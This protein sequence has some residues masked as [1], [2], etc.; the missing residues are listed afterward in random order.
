MRSAQ[1]IGRKNSVIVKTICV[2]SCSIGESH[3]HLSGVCSKWPHSDAGAPAGATPDGH[4]A[5]AAEQGCGGE[6]LS[7]HLAGFGG[8][9]LIGLIAEMR[10]RRGNSS[11]LRRSCVAKLGAD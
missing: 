9:A 7:G 4:I 5:A 10:S 2:A 8:S 3:P 1:K 6:S 11:P